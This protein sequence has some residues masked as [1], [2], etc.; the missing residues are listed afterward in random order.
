MNIYQIN[1]QIEEI[2]ANGFY[3]D[4]ET[5]ELKGEED[6]ESLQMEK[7]EKIENTALYVKNLQA[8]VKAMRDEEQNLKDRR[9]AV[10][11]KI[12]NIENYLANVC[13]LRP[14]TSSK[15]AVSFRKSVVCEI[16]NEDSIPQEYRKVKETVTIDKAGIKEVLKNGGTVEGATLIE[17][18]NITIK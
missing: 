15:C 16:T 11:S 3:L 12:A 17:K 8:L 18:N 10:E 13:E 1:N 4:E 6:L 9:T 7:T 5:G 14:F 2:L